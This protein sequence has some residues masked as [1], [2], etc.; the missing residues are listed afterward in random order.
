MPYNRII[1][2]E[3]ATKELDSI[4]HYVAEKSQS[5]KIAFEL[6]DSIFQRTQQLSIMPL[7]GQVEPNLESYD[8]R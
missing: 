2:T 8:V 3:F 7:S 1:W 4:F 5:Y 6:I